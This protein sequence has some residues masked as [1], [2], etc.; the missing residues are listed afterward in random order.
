[1][2]YGNTCSGNFNA[3]SFTVYQEIFALLI[4]HENGRFK[5]FVECIFANDPHGQ[6]ESCGMATLSQNRFSQRSQ[7][8]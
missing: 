1:M 7:D 3:Q 5:I 2:P 6:E 8:T 4:F